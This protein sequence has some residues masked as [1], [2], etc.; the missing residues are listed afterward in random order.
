MKTKYQ[1]L[2][3]IQGKKCAGKGGVTSAD[4]KAVAKEYVAD[5]IRKGKSKKEAEDIAHNVTSKCSVVSGF[6][7]TKRKVK[8]KVSGTKSKTRKK[9]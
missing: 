2:L 6:K 1:K 3:A 8:R 9:R 7:K 5:S 4:V